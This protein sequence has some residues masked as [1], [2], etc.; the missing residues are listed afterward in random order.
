MARPAKT[1]E[2]IRL[3][4]KAHRTK[5]ELVVREKAEKA[6]LFGYPVTETEE[7][8]TDPVAHGEFQRVT[9]ILSTIG[10]NDESFGASVRRY[11]MVYSKMCDNEAT[12]KSLKAKARKTADADAVV[13]LEDLIDRKDRKGAGLRKE[14]LDLERETGLTMAS[15]LRLIPKA[16][17][18]EANPFMALMNG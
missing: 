5:A 15:S 4:G 14:L 1:A 6:T 9:T 8:R 11:C 13:K 7:I 12:I 16:P 18:K 10:K 3:E 17:E 2:I